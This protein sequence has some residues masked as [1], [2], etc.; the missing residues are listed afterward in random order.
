MSTEPEVVLT[1]EQQV[2]IAK[3]ATAQAQAD[4]AK[5]NAR[6]AELEKE[7]RHLRAR[8][9]VKKQINSV[10]I[11]SLHKPEELLTLLRQEPGVSIE[12]DATGENLIVTVDGR[13][14]SMEEIVKDYALNIVRNST[15][16]RCADCCPTTTLK[17]FS[18]VRTCATAQRCVSSFA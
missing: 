5:A 15:S 11:K 4:I 6:T 1:A 18:H 12:P 2:E 7:A 10:A 8:D 17:K 3:A 14:S 16:E 13:E 9:T